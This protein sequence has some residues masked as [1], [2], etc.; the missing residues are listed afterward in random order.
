MSPKRL[1]TQRKAFTFQHVAKK[2]CVLGLGDLCTDMRHPAIVGRPSGERFATCPW[3]EQMMWRI[4][5]PQ[6]CPKPVWFS[7]LMNI[8]P[9]CD[10]W[11]Q[12]FLNQSQL[13]SHWPV[14][15]L[16]QTIC[17]NCGPIRSLAD[18]QVAGWVDSFLDKVRACAVQRCPKVSEHVCWITEPQLFYQQPCNWLAGPM[19]EILS[20][21]CGCF[22]Q[23]FSPSL[24][25]LFAHLRSK[26]RR[27]AQ[28]RTRAGS[29]T[30]QVVRERPIAILND[31]G[32]K[33]CQNIVK[34]TSC[35]G[36]LMKSSQN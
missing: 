29:K 4:F 25:K 34:H 9:A 22:A 16:P 24:I 5:E 28:Q 15:H 13:T 32:V 7:I 31:Y 6:N 18:E 26:C 35:T 1:A 2:V 11:T 3:K 33:M 19:P 17:V 27:R 20:G 10:A 36:I 21:T 12:Q 23:A 30:A 8:E 14:N